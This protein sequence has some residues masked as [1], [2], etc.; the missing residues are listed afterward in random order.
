MNRIKYDQNLLEI[1]ALISRLSGAVIKDCL[2]DEEGTLRV[3]VEPG[4]MGKIIGKGG[5]TIQRIQQI[6]NK[7]VMALEF[8]PQIEEFIKNLIY[9]L[10]GIQ[11]RIEEEKVTFLCQDRKAKGLLI[12][13]EKKN[14]NFIKETL[15]RYFP[16]E[17]VIVN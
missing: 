6:L 15:R 17:E 5:S 2:Y 11:V 9:P 7:K 4:E 8:A 16:I 1:M 3:V 14:V 12:G 10:R 13:R